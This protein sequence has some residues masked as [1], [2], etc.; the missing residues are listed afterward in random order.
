MPENNAFKFP[1]QKILV[2]LDLSEA[3]VAAWKQAVALARPWGAKVEGL[4]VQ[5]W[6]HSAMGL[7]TGE[8]YLTAQAGRAA[9]KSLRL[10]L[11]SG[12]DVRSVSGSVEETILSWGKYLGFDLIVM[13]THGR[14]GLERAIKGSIAETVIRHSSIPVLALRKS[15]PR[16][17]R[18]L[19]PVNFKPYAL[20]GLLFA[21]KVASALGARL[22]VLHALSAPLYADE[23][24]MQAPRQ[25]LEEAVGSLPARLR[26]ACRPQTLLAFGKPAEEIARAAEEADLVVLVA[27]RKGALSDAFLGTTA[28][29]VLR[30][31]PQPVL[32]I[33]M[34]T[35][36][37]P[38]KEE[39][40]G[41]HRHPVAGS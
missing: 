20:N 16:L 41:A 8:P 29:R 2:P 10:R 32:V 37:T 36:S 17:R 25:L 18:V 38:K 19:A 26:H 31:C 22:K 11:G 3:S 4:Y 7:G 39:A 9:L 28:E 33:P 40:H 6:L 13:G 1:P 35:A 15:A 12:A 30:H 24:A 23:S 34:R 27:H 21:A 5:E 14:S